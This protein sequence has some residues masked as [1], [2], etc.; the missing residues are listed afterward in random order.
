MIKRWIEESV[1]E[2]LAYRRGV[3]LTGARQ[4]GKTTL[5]K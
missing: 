1:R 5:P 2:S 3:N 4:V